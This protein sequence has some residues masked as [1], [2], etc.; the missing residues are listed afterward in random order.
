MLVVRRLSP[1][2]VIHP[3]SIQTELHERTSGN[4]LNIPPNLDMVNTPLIQFPGNDGSEGEP[5]YIISPT[6]EEVVWSRLLVAK[7]HN[8]SSILINV[9]H[10]SSHIQRALS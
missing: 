9:R 3:Q 4:V 10:Y 6:C 2:R 5:R 7:E 8:L 1:V